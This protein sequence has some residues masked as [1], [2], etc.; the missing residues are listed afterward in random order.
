MRS[1]LLRSA[2][3][4]LAV[5]GMAG[6][7]QAAPV[8][9]GTLNFA[10]NADSLFLDPVLNDNNADIWILTN[11]NSTLLEPTPDGKSVRPGLATSWGASPNGKTFTLKL[12]PGIKFA[13]GSPVTTDDVVW[14]LNRAKDPKLG[15]WNFLLTSIDKVAAEGSDTIVLSLKNPDPSLPAALATFNSSI[16]PQK[17][18]ETSKGATEEEKAHSFAE[19]PVGAGPFMLD[20]WQR[21]SKM[22]LKRNPNYWGT[23]ASGAALPYLDQ[24]VLTVV[25]D[26]ATRILQLKAGQVDATEFVPYERAKEL[27]GDPNLTMEL[28]PS[29]QVTYVQ[30]NAR[31]K[32]NDGS[33][34]PLGNEKVRQA[35]NY[36][37][38]K[39]AII[40]I[41]T[42]GLGT[43]MQ[44]YMSSTT[45][46]YAALGP[47]YPYDMKKAKALLAE[48]GYSKGFSLVAF[49]QAGKSDDTSTLAA[50][51]QMWTPLGVKLSIQQMDLPTLSARYHK[52]DFQMR[53][54]YWTNDIADPN[55]ITS[56]FAYYPNI[57]SQFSGWK[58]DRVDTL[59][60]Q[61]QTEQDKAKRVAMYQEIQQIY[62]QGA[63]MFFMFESPFADATRKQVKGF[64]QIPLG[65][66]VFETA[67]IQK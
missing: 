52:N 57:Q 34:N 54:G 26:D 27:Q 39:K 55:E 22:V 16:M 35:L 50:M 62:V 38:N 30:L 32:L 49:S 44:S 53:T 9:G 64:M 51:Q 41:V 10:R 24:V 13:D 48:A 66:D 4:G 65:N 67:Y 42:H 25:P 47:A 61:S 40:Q 21:G 1:V 43:P 20:S 19:H 23:D 7:A 18:F 6:V 2:I 63:P 56:Y 46:L 14:S 29:T 17:L 28:F 45:P 37:L 12:R 8:R 5:A 31:P 11:I 15:I 33:D 60:E 58:S 36:A 59:F 3:M